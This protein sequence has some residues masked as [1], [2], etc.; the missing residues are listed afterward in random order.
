MMDETTLGPRTA[1]F[2]VRG[3][4][5]GGRIWKAI[6]AIMSEVGA[7]GKDRKNAGQGYNFRGIDD[8]YFAV[9]LVLAKHGV[10][11]VPE[12]LEER[13]EDRT[14]K[15][16]AAL[17]YRVL[18]IRFWFY[19][20]D[21]SFFT[22][23]VMGEGMDSGD[24]ASNKAMSV[25]HKYAFLQVLAIP[26]AEPKDPE[27]DSHEVAPRIAGIATFNYEIEDHRAIARD[28]AKQRGITNV[29]VVK[30][31]YRALA[32]RPL[33]EVRELV[34]TWQVPAAPAQGAPQ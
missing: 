21:G 14:T 32:G 2:D 22:A 26:T 20:D 4:P 3:A 17:I 34:K 11:T 12:V 8:V 9:Q 16:G 28:A 33:N 24:K 30:Q 1:D 7:I 27:N 25:A 18:K 15:G 5:R 19:A 10:F 23:T 6:P 31:L 29:E 13:T